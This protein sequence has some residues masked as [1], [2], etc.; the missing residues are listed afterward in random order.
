MASRKSTSLVQDTLT[1]VAPFVVLGGVG[2]LWHKKGQVR[3]W[4]HL[5]RQEKM[6]A[7]FSAQWEAS[8][9]QTHQH[10]ERQLVSLANFTIESAKKECLEKG[11]PR[12]TL[13]WPYV[14]REFYHQTGVALDSGFAQGENLK[15]LKEMVSSRVSA[16]WKV[17][18]DSD[19][20]MYFSHHA[21]S[22]EKK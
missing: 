18:F 6:D 19:Y 16:P 3:Q 9:R 14:C 5:C 4:I 12:A 21:L 20:R 10:H 22:E 2:Y 1:A 7:R 13:N 17:V 8:L 15:K 11:Q